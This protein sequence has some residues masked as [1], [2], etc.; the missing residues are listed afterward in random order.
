MFNNYNPMTNQF[1]MNNYQ[2]QMNQM[3]NQYQPQNQTLIRVTGIDGAKAYP[4]QPNSVVPLFDN[5]ND[6]MYIKTTELEDALDKVKTL[7]DDGETIAKFYRNTVFEKMREIR[8]CVDKAEL[9]TASK[10]WP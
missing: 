10:Y 2:N 8:T 9:I 5:D 7:G 4:M 3:Q 1:M 6:I